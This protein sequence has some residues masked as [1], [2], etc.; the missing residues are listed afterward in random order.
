MAY[1]EGLSGSRKVLYFVYLSPLKFSEFAKI[2]N[3]I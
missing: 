2:I 1:K 3:G